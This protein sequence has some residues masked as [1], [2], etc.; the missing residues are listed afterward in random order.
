MIVFTYG[1]EWGDNAG[2]TEK[3]Q[4]RLRD[5]AYAKLDNETALAPCIFPVGGTLRSALI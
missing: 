3:I 1:L 2:A 5:T 4:Q